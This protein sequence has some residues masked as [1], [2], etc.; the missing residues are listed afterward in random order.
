[1]T[2]SC[3]KADRLGLDCYYYTVTSRHAMLP[4]AMLNSQAVYPLFPLKCIG[5]Q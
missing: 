4:Y 3:Y 1:M 5:V 2:I